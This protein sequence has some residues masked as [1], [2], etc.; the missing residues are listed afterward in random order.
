MDPIG[1]LPAVDGKRGAPDGESEVKRRRLVHDEGRLIRVVHELELTGMFYMDSTDDA[2]TSVG[3][4]VPAET[5]P[6]IT[7][8]NSL[9]IEDIKRLS[10]TYVEIDS[11]AHA[12]KQRIQIFGAVACV[13]RS[14]LMLARVLQEVLPTEQITMIILIPADAVG[15]II[16][17]GGSGLKTIREAS[18]TQLDVERDNDQVFNKR[19][20]SV[21]GDAAI[22]IACALY[23]ILRTPKFMELTDVTNQPRGNP[24]PIPHIPGEPAPYIP[25]EP[26]PY[27]H[28]HA[29]SPVGHALSA[30]PHAHGGHSLYHGGSPQAAHH[31]DP[32]AQHQVHQVQHSPPPVAHQP[33]SH[34]QPPTSHHVIGHSLATAVHPHA[35]PAHYA[36]P[37]HSAQPGSHIGHTSVAHA[38]AAMSANVTGV[39]R[40]PYNVI[41]APDLNQCRDWIQAGNAEF[42]ASGIT[43]GRY[44]FENDEDTFQ[45]LIPDEFVSG[46]INRGGEGVNEIKR[47]CGVAVSFQ[48]RDQMQALGISE[49]KCQIKGSVA[50]IT[51]AI[52]LIMFCM[53]RMSGMQ[54]ISFCIL[55]EHKNAGIVIGKGGATFKEIRERT[56]VRLEIEPQSHPSFGGGRRMTFKDA[57]SHQVGTTF[58]EV[59]RVIKEFT[60]SAAH[61][62]HG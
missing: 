15:P 49:R 7:V 26:A 25:G 2:P 56:G 43:G 12:G 61:L 37:G 40:A 6:A 3:M 52:Y 16:G 42:R 23:R 54:Q 30:S 51:A 47:L 31:T 60:A 13:T 46:I 4:L 53:L 34:H 38:A 36:P 50:S 10:H 18:M 27:A 17:K 28:H 9:A 14:I 32:Y 58:L 57:T 62:H 20:I 24:A 22:K 48:K 59:V 11:Q 21:R 39:Q 44:M 41:I 1:L 45:L 5:I 35:P 29:P 55:I 19:R 8:D 33:M